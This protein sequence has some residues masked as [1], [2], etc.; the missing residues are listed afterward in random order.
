MEGVKYIQCYHGLAAYRGGK[1][2][3]DIKSKAAAAVKATHGLCVA[4]TAIGDIGLSLMARL[5]TVFRSDCRS[6]TLKDGRRECRETEWGDEDVLG[7]FTAELGAFNAEWFTQALGKF[8]TKK[9]ILEFYENSEVESGK[10]LEGWTGAP[11]SVQSVWC[12]LQASAQ[13]KAL[14][15]ELANE[16]GVPVRLVSEGESDL[17][18]NKSDLTQVESLEI[19][20]DDVLE[21]F[22]LTDADW[23]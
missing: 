21:R 1:A 10:Y 15:A 3:E 18:G 13:M 20:E 7:Y 19:V 17:W 9:E 16:L 11:A 22:G 6:Y 4:N 5:T 14:A 2:V 12:K 23:E 8:L